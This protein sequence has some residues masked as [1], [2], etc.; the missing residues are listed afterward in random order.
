VGITE[1]GDAKGVYVSMET[2]LTISIPE[3]RWI[4]VAD[5]AAIAGLTTEAVRTVVR[6][7]KIRAQSRA[8]DENSRQV[9]YVHYDDLMNHLDS[10]GSSAARRV[11]HGGKPVMQMTYKERALHVAMQHV[12][13]ARKSVVSDEERQVTL[14]VLQRLM[15]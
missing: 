3:D 7:G 8:S 1:K 4:R 11:K 6:S 5:A 10:P 15:E 12:R 13:K 2:Q 9:L 14:E